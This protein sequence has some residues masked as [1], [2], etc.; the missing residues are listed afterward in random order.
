MSHTPPYRL[1]SERLVVRCWQPSD[2]PLLDEAIASSIDHLKEWLP[3]IA[4]E[5]LALP[6]R[7]EYLRAVRARFDRDEDYT[8][9]VFDRREER[10]LGASGLHKRSTPEVLEIGYWIRADSARRGL[11][12]ELAAMLSHVALARCNA[13]RVEIHCD[14]NNIASQ[15]V[16]AKL[17]YRR[18]AVLR[19][20]SRTPEGA[21]RDTV[22]WSL[23]ADELA[24][25]P[26]A[27]VVYTA[28]DACGDVVP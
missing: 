24:S 4:R 1:E 5:P 8:V 21:E 22:I 27:D 6:D 7:V 12:T 20:R 11:C 18:D 3:W 28:F 23:F 9:A 26:C 13:Q 15:G 17:G 10:V 19:R 14:P 25:S 16:P 2:A